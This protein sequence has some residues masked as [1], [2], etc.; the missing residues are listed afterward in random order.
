MGTKYIGLK[1]D[2]SML[3]AIRNAPMPLTKEQ[4]KFIENEMAGDEA[5]LVSNK[6]A[7]ASERLINFVTL[8]RNKLIYRMFACRTKIDRRKK[9]NGLRVDIVEVLR[10]MEGCA[11]ALTKNITVNYMCGKDWKAVYPGEVNRERFLKYKPLYFSNNWDSGVQMVDYLDFGLYLQCQGYKV[12]DLVVMKPELKYS[13]ITPHDNPIMFLAK[14]N[15]CPGMEL[16]RKLKFNKLQQSKLALNRLNK[17]DKGFQKFL[18]KCAEAGY[19]HEPYQTYSAYYKRHKYDMSHW[20]EELK[21]QELKIEILSHNKSA[22]YSWN[23]EEKFDSTI[24][25]L[26]ELSLYLT[27]KDIEFRFYKDYYDLCIKVGH[28]MEDPYWMYPNDFHKANQK[29]MAEYDNVKKLNSKLKY[30]YLK[31]VLVG[32]EKEPMKIGG[33]DVFITSDIEKIKKQCDTLYQCLIRNDYI[34]KVIQQEEILVFFWKDGEPK[35]TAEVFYNGKVG[36]FYGDERDRTTCQ[37]PEE[38]HQYLGEFLKT[39]E[40]KKRKVETKIKYFKG[41]YDKKADGTFV[42]WNNYQFVIGGIYATE[43]DDATIERAGATGCNATN[44]VFHFCESIEEIS[45][46]YSPKYYCEVEPLGPVLDCNGALL[47]NKLRIV[48]EVQVDRI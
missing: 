18:F 12:E 35:Y 32:M 16:L 41:F 48:R 46:H 39:I 42:G 8:Y 45:K 31:E 3:D 22:S 27:R 6:W 11:Y 1:Y 34:G 15:M 21:Y 7:K 13:Q 43:F 36:Q 25:D 33:Y 47:T 30:E 29:V 2:S 38:L 4:E 26:R 20:N 19:I 40:L 14:Y 24:Y 17:N 5:W 44:K 9:D 23:R 28:N 10:G 37:A